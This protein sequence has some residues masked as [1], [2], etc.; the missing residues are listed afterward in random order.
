[1][2]KLIATFLP[3]IESTTKLDLTTSQLSLMDVRSS[4]LLLSE[5][6]LKAIR[7]GFSLEGRNSLTAP[8]HSGELLSPTRD[9]NA[10]ESIKDGSSPGRPASM[11]PKITT[12]T[13]VDEG[14]GTSAQ[15]SL[16][17]VPLPSLAGELLPGQKNGSQLT[18]RRV[19]APA[20]QAQ[21]VVLVNRRAGSSYYERT[22]SIDVQTGQQ[23]S[24]CELYPQDQISELI[25]PGHALLPKQVDPESGQSL[26]TDET[27]Q[28]ASG[29]DRWIGI[30]QDRRNSYVSEQVIT[31]RQP[32]QAQDMTA[33]GVQQ[34]RRASE[35][36]FLP[37]QDPDLSQVLVI[38][39]QPASGSKESG[40]QRRLQ[41]AGS[42]QTKSYNQDLEEASNIVSSTSNM[43][44]DSKA[45]NKT[46]RA[47][48]EEW[49]K[50]EA[51]YKKKLHASIVSNA[52]SKMELLEKEKE[53]KFA[54]REIE[55]LKKRLR[56]MMHL[57][58]EAELLKRKSVNAT[59]ESIAEGLEKLSQSI[60][61][62]IGKCHCLS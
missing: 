57:A 56:E 8:R 30:P 29:S 37:L 27:S 25:V 19:S 39:S 62:P 3:D 47:W 40:D 26:G 22:S 9:P 24:I 15:R 7:S 31:Q 54:E 35:Q 59:E 10:P 61:S 49:A 16:P 21:D 6:K 32:G 58:A 2:D 46:G 48:E 17:R 28:V 38:N 50:K 11:P 44:D 1:M 4:L 60:A 53:L 14:G 5:S 55:I 13:D 33:A 36:V 34:E 45:T 43:P 23:L 20:T 42:L 12:P 52:Q 51:K 18:D 41:S